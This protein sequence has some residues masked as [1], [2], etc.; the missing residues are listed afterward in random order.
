[1]LSPELS[2]D[3][4]CPFQKLEVSEPT[5]KDIQTLVKLRTTKSKGYQHPLSI[6][7]KLH[8]LIKPKVCEESDLTKVLVKLFLGS[9]CLANIY[10]LDLSVEYRS[11]G[12]SL[13]RRKSFE[14]QEQLDE[15]SSLQSSITRITGIINQI[16][17]LIE[18]YVSGSV[19]AGEVSLTTHLGLLHREIL[20]LIHGDFLA[21]LRDVMSNELE[22][23]LSS[24]YCLLSNTTLQKL[25]KMKE[26]TQCV[27]AK[28]AK[29]W[30]APSWE[31]SLTLEENIVKAVPHLIHFV[32]AGAFEGLNIFAFQMPAEYGLSVDILAETTR[33]VLVVL[34]NEDPMERNCLADDIEH[35][36]WRFSFNGEQVFV[37]TTGPCYGVEN[38][39]FAF[40]DDAT[41]LLIQP[42][43][44][45][46]SQK[47][48]GIGGKET[49]SRKI[50]TL[51]TQAG[52]T[53]EDDLIE[54]ARYVMPVRF[55]SPIV[56]W[57]K[58]LSES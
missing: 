49:I 35:E 2:N 8:K 5:I 18:S 4:K 54:A 55:G 25:E 27:F 16:K 51:F 1:M 7:P 6:V 28:T 37:I 48:W 39:R 53:Y 58:G 26:G 46:K 34:N 9:I 43:F 31:S 15:D 22:D 57:W 12:L 42:D 56:K 13:T 24:D 20:Q 40:C 41:F 21:V 11:L 44:S 30:G 10:Y 3:G 32:T 45:F 36:N 47:S 38:S 50:R 23:F 14:K 52:R 17:L 19:K 33:R 29:V